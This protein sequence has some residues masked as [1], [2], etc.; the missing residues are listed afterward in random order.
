MKD[1]YGRER[2]VLSIKKKF[3]EDCPK[4]F[5]VVE[6]FERAFKLSNYSIGRIEKYWSFLKPSIKK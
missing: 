6:K 2:K 3:K 5:K 1:L 4:C